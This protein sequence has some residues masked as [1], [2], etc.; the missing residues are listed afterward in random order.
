M[1]AADAA[2]AKVYASEMLGRTCDAA[3]SKMM[4]DYWGIVQ[5]RAAMDKAYDAEKLAAQYETTSVT[6]AKSICK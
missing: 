3:V 2:M 5:N 1:T 6:D 4:G